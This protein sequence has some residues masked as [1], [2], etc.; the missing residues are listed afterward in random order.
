KTRVHPPNEELRAPAFG[1][2]DVREA[3]A[4]RRPTRR[5]MRARSGNERALFACLRVH[6]PDRAAT[7]VR[8]EIVPV[9]YVGDDA[10][11]GMDLWVRRP[12]QSEYVASLK[13]LAGYL[14]RR[15]FHRRVRDDQHEEKRQNPAHGFLLKNRMAHSVVSVAA[16]QVVTLLCTAEYLTTPI[17]PH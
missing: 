1:R 4:I 9:A 6:Q 11:V 8:H 7:L 5:L 14:R 17:G 13:Q 12:L 16:D 10:A 2:G 15:C 3:L